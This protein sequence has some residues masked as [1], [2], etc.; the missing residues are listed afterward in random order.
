MFSQIDYSITKISEILL[1]DLPAL[2]PKF[3]NLFRHHGINLTTQNFCTISET[4]TCMCWFV[5]DATFFLIVELH[6]GWFW[7]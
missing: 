7:T 6:L 5:V 4:K 3:G 1:N 2:V